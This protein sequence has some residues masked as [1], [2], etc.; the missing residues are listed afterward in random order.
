MLIGKWWKIENNVVCKL[1]LG[2]TGSAER[3]KSSH[4]LAPVTAPQPMRDNVA[5]P[6]VSCSH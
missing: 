3:E 4:L 5:V 6:R 1:T 2:A